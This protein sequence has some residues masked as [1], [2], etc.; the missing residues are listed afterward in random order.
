[1]PRQEVEDSTIYKVVVSDQE[2]YSIWPADRELP[3]GWNDVGFQGSKQQCLHHI[4]EVW[5]ARPPPS[6]R[7]RMSGEAR[8]RSREE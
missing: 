5:D 1:M 6:P 3:P 7:T 8:A 2:M 4:V